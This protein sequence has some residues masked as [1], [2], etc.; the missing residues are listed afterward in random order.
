MTK[1]GYFP[2]NDPDCSFVLTDPG[3]PRPWQA[4]LLNERQMTQ[5]EVVK[6]EIQVKA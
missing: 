2:Q 5:A 6:V 1:H 4:Y 3:N